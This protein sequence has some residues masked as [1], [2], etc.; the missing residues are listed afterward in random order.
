MLTR[1]QSESD[2]IRTRRDPLRY[3]VWGTAAALVGA[4][5]LL[6]PLRLWPA[7]RATAGPF[8]TLAVLI[9]GGMLAD[10]VGLFGLLA[11]QLIPSHASSRVAFA[12]V[13][14]FAA[15]LSGLMNLDVA[16]VVAMPVALR[17]ARQAKLSASRLC[18]ATAL[19]ANAASFR[20]RPRT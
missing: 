13:L 8:L 6:D 11:R 4:A 9:A 10:R 19:T 2:A 20:C 1:V 7:A 3:A 17:V 14:V 18:V 5:L 16:V 12:A 15:I